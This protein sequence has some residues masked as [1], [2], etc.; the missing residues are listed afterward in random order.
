MYTYLFYF[1]ATKVSS[2]IA[3]TYDIYPQEIKCGLNFCALFYKYA[4]LLWNPS[5]KAVNLDKYYRAASLSEDRLQ[6]QDHSS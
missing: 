4:I 6:W 3:S 1:A 5:Q 2:C